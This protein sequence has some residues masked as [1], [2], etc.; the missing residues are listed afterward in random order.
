GRMF[1]VHPHEVEAG[2]GEQ[3]EHGG[4]ANHRHPGAEL[5][6]AS[7]GTFAIRV[8]GHRLATSKTKGTAALFAPSRSWVIRASGTGT[9]LPRRPRRVRFSG[10]PA[11]STGWSG[12]A[13]FAS[14]STSM[15]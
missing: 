11:T 5:G 9:P 7:L 8:R 2:G 15:T 6:L 10:S 12:S 13:R 3:G 4:G 14:C 1:H